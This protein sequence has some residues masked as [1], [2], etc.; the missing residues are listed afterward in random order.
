MKLFSGREPDEP[1]HNVSEIQERID[2]APPAPA[3]T[4]DPREEI[5][6]EIPPVDRSS[7]TPDERM[8]RAEATLGN[9]F[10]ATKKERLIAY[11]RHP[12][13]VKPLMLDYY[14]R[15]LFKTSEFLG[16]KN[17]LQA[18]ESIGPNFYAAE[19]D[20]GRPRSQTMILEDTP[21]GFR[22]DWEY[23]VQYNPMNWSTFLKE[24]PAAPMDFRVYANLA[25]DYRH[26]FNDE[27]RYIGVNLMTL[28][29]TSEIMGYAE[30]NS[31]LGKRIERFLAN[32]HEELCILRLQFASPPNPDTVH[33]R[34]LVNPHWI[35]TDETPD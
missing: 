8:D 30:R 18:A 23:Y 24:M 14:S 11:V 7:E 13:R 16:L 12:E 28:N 5:E 22:V 2:R 3:P 20:I 26:P 4:D 21:K 29:D 31:E 19:A 35:I 27:S 6:T 17:D 9:F 15:E 1:L 33:I 34:E 32:K 25:P 10:G